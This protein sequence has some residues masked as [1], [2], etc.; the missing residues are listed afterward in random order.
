MGLVRSSSQKLRKTE[1]IA[2]NAISPGPVNT[3][4]SDVMQDLVPVHHFTPL[5]VIVDALD[6]ILDDDITGQVVECSSQ[7]YYLRE[8]VGYCDGSAKFLLEDMKRFVK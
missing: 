8:P 7:A 5:S 3:T 4:L 2:L 6:K 1:S